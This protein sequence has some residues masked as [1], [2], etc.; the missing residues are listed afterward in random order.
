MTVERTG[1]LNA[2]PQYAGEHGCRTYVGKLPNGH[3][4]MKPETVIHDGRMYCDKHRPEVGTEGEGAMDNIA[5]W[6]GTF[7]RPFA[8]KRTLTVLICRCGWL[9]IASCKVEVNEEHEDHKAGREGHGNPREEDYIAASNPLTSE[10]IASLKRDA[11]IRGRE[12]EA[13]DY[14]ERWKVATAELG[15]GCCDCG[16]AEDYGSIGDTASWTLRKFVYACVALMVVVGA[17]VAWRFLR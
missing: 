10:A 13:I 15:L 5:A 2:T 9:T 8:P 6:P 11:Y 17:A 7:Q 3:V 14:L 1:N 4:C 12:S 16:V